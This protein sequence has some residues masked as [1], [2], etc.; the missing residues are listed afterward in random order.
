M[1]IKLKKNKI[2]KILKCLSGDRHVLQLQTYKKIINI[3]YY[4]LSFKKFSHR[5]FLP[6]KSEKLPSISV[7]QMMIP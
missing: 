2:W 1:E 4:I 7:F 5:F 3:V 6:L